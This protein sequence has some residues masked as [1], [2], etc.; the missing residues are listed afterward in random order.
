MTERVRRPMLLAWLA[1][2]LL[3]VPVLA[4]ALMEYGPERSFFFAIYLLVWAIAFLVSGLI[5]ARLEPAATVGAVLA[6][7][8]AWSTALVLAAIAALFTIS[9]MLVP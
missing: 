7:A 2:P 8:A 3:A 6:R 4:W 1:A 9:F 5:V